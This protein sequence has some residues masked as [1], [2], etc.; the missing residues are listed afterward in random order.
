MPSRFVR[1]D[2]QSAAPGSVGK[3]SS[4]SVNESNHRTGTELSW[5]MFSDIIMSEKFAQLCN[6][7]LENFQGLKAEKL[8]DLSLINSRMK[9]GAYESSPVLFYSDIQQVCFAL[10][11]NVLIVTTFK[12]S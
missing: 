8:L 10:P 9:E 1:D 3:T 7:L 4:G 5:S 2:I 6:L 12:Y 11:Y